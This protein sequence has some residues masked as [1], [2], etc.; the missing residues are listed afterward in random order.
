[1]VV[2]QGGLRTNGTS[3]GGGEMVVSI[4]SMF[5]VGMHVCS[6]VH[7]YYLTLFVCFAPAYISCLILLRNAFFKLTCAHLFNTT[8]SHLVTICVSLH[9]LRDGLRARSEPKRV[10][11]CMY[12]ICI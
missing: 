1:M 9:G 6:W 5:T 8:Y 10:C 7:T 2:I 4:L 12:Y 11:I 3:D